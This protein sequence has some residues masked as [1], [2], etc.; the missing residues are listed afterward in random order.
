LSCSAPQPPN[1]T[2]GLWKPCGTPP[3]ATSDLPSAA[4]TPRPTNTAR[5]EHAHHQMI[6][7]FRN[8]D[9]GAV[10]AS[11]LHHLDAN[12]QS[13]SG[14]S[15]EPNRRAQHAVPVIAGRG[16]AAR[17]AGC[18]HDDLGALVGGQAQPGPCRRDPPLNRGDA[19]S[20]SRTE[21]VLHALER[22][23]HPQRC[24]SLRWPQ[25]MCG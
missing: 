16:K 22:G 3:N 8:R 7:A 6:D 5:R 9:P 4:W 2:S 21:H 18:G 20:Q 25:G 24:P 17:G 11:G 10:S 13:P 15:S 14:P 23:K 19:P 12:E 1:G